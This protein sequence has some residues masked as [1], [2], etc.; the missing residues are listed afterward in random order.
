MSTL[1]CEQKFPKKCYSFLTQ[2]IKNYILGLLVC[3]GK[4][5]CSTISSTIA[6]PYHSVHR[7]FDD[8][9]SREG[10]A[11][12]FLINLVKMHETKDNPGILIVDSTQI[13]KIYGEKSELLCYDHNGSMKTVLKGISCVVAAWTNGKIVIPLAFDFWIREKDIKDDSKYQKKTTISKKLILGLKGKT[14]FAYTTLDGDYGNEGFLKF[15]HKYDLKFT[16]RMPSNRKIVIGEIEETLKKHPALKLSRNQR[17][18]KVKGF[19]KGVPVIV[20]AHKRKGK[21]NTKQVVFIVSN[22]RGLSAKEHVKA[23]ACRWPIEKM[24]RTM[25]QKLG[26]EDCQSISTKKQCA[27]IF[28]NFIAFT[29]L[30][31]QKINKKKKSPDEALKFFRSQNLAKKSQPIID[32]EGFMM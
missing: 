16:V 21:N 31:M 1:Q 11:Q 14:P 10:E 7:C 23:Y 26:L 20:I 12:D 9:E 19:Y 27:H 28:A 32:L 25:K 8:L 15:L 4:K 18:K 22:L 5:N 29:E 2:S 6:V 3:T 17:Y 24:F 13:K 30:E